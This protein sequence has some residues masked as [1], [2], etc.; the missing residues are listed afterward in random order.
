MNCRSISYW[1]NKQELQVNRLLEYIG[2]SGQYVTRS[3]HKECRSI[4]YK[5]NTWGVQV[6]KVLT[7]YIGITGEELYSKVI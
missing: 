7:E 4:T 2:I 6:N 3:M 1:D 5:Q